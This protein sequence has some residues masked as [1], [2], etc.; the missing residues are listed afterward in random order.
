MRLSRPVRGRILIAIEKA[1][2][3]RAPLRDV[4]GACGRIDHLS[5]VL[6]HVREARPVAGDHHHWV[7]DDEAGPPIE[8]DTVVT[9]FGS[10]R[11][12]A[13]ETVAGSVVRHGG[14]LAFRPNGDGSTRVTLGLSYALPPG[15]F[16]ERV[17]AL[18]T[19]EEVETAL[20]RWRARMEA[21]TPAA[22]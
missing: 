2:D 5:Q 21:G 10:N 3:V 19:S 8:W 12:I 18:V 7:M 1:I 9:R 4:F 6:P 22:R 11:V 17:A 20:R 13:W 14:Q 16:G 15:Q